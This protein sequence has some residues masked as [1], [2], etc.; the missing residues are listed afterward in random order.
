MMAKVTVAKEM[1]FDGYFLA[2]GLQE[3]EKKL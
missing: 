1:S 2:N 3:H